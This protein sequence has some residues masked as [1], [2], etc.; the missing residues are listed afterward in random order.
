MANIIGEPLP[1]YTIKQINARQQIHGKGVP[2]YNSNQ[3]SSPRTLK[4]LAILN[5]NTSWI[6]LA[7]GVSVSS[8]K[9]AELVSQG[10]INH[11]YQD[12]GLAKNFILFGGTSY[13]T[14]SSDVLQPRF[15]ISRD[16]NYGAYGFGYGTSKNNSNL[17]FVPMPG[18][19]SVAVKTLNRGSIKK[20]TIKIKAHSKVQFD[21]IDVLYM[22]LGYSVLLEWGNS[23]FFNA[24]IRDYKV[25]GPTLTETQFFKYP[26]GSTTYLELLPTI[27]S[28]RSTYSGNYDALLGKI[29]NF[30]WTFNP[31]G[32]YDISIDVISLGDVIES[33][34]TNISFPNEIASFIEN[35]TTLSPTTP[36]ISGSGDTDLIEDNKSSNIISSHLWLWK[37][38]DGINTTTPPSI[39]VDVLG[40][41]T[42]VGRFLGNSNTSVTTVEDMDVLEVIEEQHHSDNGSDS[43]SYTKTPK[44]Y[45]GTP[46]QNDQTIENY[47]ANGWGI[48]P[49]KK[50]AGT[51]SALVDY[52]QWIE[53]KRKPTETIT[54]PLPNNNNNIFKLYISPESSGYYMDFRY[55][56]NFIKDKVLPKIKNTTANIPIFNID[57][58]FS[59]KNIMYTL[60]NQMS[61]DP[62]V[63]LVRNDNFDFFDGSN[64]PSK[65]YPE[66]KQFQQ[67]LS[68]G[69]FAF[70]YPLN[71][72]LNF[73]FI[74]NCLDQNSDERGDVALFGFISSICSGLNE[75]LGGINNLEPVIDES[76]N[77]LKIIDS[78]PLPNSPTSKYTPYK[79]L[80]YGYSPN[81]DE[82]T[83]IRNIDLKTAITP[84]YASMV[85]IGA[86]AG[87]YVK[88]IEAT[89]FAKWNKGITDRFKESY[90]PGDEIFTT[91]SEDDAVEN[92]TTQYL[93]KGIEVMGISTSTT[94]LLT[95]P[96]FS[97]IFSTTEF[98]QTIIDKNKSVVTEFYK[99]V[100]AE[101]SKNDP[102]NGSASSVGFIP[103]KLGLTMDGLSGIKIYN[104]IQMDTTFFP[105][106]YPDV[107]N[108][109]VTGVNHKLQN[110][111]W[112]TEIETMVIPKNVTPIPALDLKGFKSIVT[113][114][115]GSRPSTC[116]TLPPLT[117]A[118]TLSLAD[119]TALAKSVFP[120]YPKT[121]IAAI[122][123]QAKVESG[124]SFD[125]L[126]YNGAGGGC[127]AFG[128]M[129]WRGTRQTELF[130]FASSRG[131]DV[132]DHLTQ[133]KFIKHEL[134]TTFTQV[135]FLLK[136]GG[137]SQYQHS[138]VIHISY[139]FGNSSPSAYVLGVTNL[140]TW[141]QFYV[142]RGGV[143]TSLIPIRYQRAQDAFALL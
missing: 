97:P 17:G 25:M 102:S 21:I 16:G 123:G 126:A 13:L 84:E 101:A 111:D 76:T 98:N 61:L 40:D 11:N 24:N 29:S 49:D 65:F 78:T 45:T 133:I 60:P 128:V 132:T 4:D 118:K 30:N 50:F 51:D 138:A 26:Q 18:I 5:S 23:S 33:L 58:A 32:S 77:S 34:K 82:S 119:F 66:L 10:L 38:L 52:Y 14:D 136:N 81:S 67:P 88:G 27:E 44:H 93:S 96:P 22:R 72:Y 35:S 117:P 15:G 143:Y 36:A 20:A 129:Q 12:T 92:Y 80:P 99:N 94:S 73:E 87:G 71:I 46:S 3:I 62:K 124:G 63:C 90:V 54:N 2:D 53:V 59:G 108:F 140:A 8:G 41:I 141:T 130:A 114:G 86:T 100:M 95:L 55:L 74:I 85:T 116:P 112:E 135:N 57:T 75:A 68:S 64:T 39:T 31:D 7:S 106:N 42:T 56:L 122:I 91:T 113:S 120:T 47:E 48:Y 105:S 142:D 28:L 131:L 9:V 43:Y 89:S 110:N 134:T 37:Y 115:G 83:F 69:G 79:L 127:G 103:F 107:L 137:L 70:A 19:E 109:I 104:S 6:K 121:A 139:G 1:E 125:T